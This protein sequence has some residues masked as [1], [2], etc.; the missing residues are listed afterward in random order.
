MID[1]AIE[2]I[3]KEAMEI[4]QPMAIA[5]EEYLTNK[6]TSITVARKLLDESKSVKGIYDQIYQKALKEAKKSRFAAIR[7]DRLR[8]GHGRSYPDRREAER[9]AGHGPC[10]RVGEVAQ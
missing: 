3:T 10:R 4:K 8:R 7:K 5:I 2:K 6:C 1:K 9:G